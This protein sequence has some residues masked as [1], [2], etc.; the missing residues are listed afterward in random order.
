MAL[1]GAARGVLQRLNGA[2]AARPLGAAMLVG[3]T[4]NIAADLIVQKVRSKAD[5]CS[6]TLHGASV[7]D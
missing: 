5:V 2:A 1:M 4:K 3:T 6:T 7:G